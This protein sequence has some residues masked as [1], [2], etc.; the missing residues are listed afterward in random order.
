MFIH[1]CFLR[2]VLLSGVIINTKYVVH[3]K[4]MFLCGYCVY[5]KGGYTHNNITKD[6]FEQLSKICCNYID[7]NKEEEEEI[8]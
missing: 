5:M 4:Y 8:V 3:I 6:E 1:F 7:D 2:E